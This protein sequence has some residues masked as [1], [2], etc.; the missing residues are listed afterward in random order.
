MKL[1]EMTNKE[2]F[3]A[4]SKLIPIAKE[5]AKDEELLNIWYRKL[6]L[7]LGGTEQDHKKEKAVYVID[8]FGDLIPYLLEHHEKNI[9]K[10]LAILN[11]KTVSEITNQSFMATL[12]Q[13]NDAMNDSA[14]Q[15]LFTM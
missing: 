9:F 3:K 1:S 2:A 6:D 14:L 8:K 15:Q 11:G 7:T 4:I 10:I 5:I 12:G 13:I